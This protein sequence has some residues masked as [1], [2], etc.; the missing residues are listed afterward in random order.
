M[1]KTK[2]GLYMNEIYKSFIHVNARAKFKK[3]VSWT[4]AWR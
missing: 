1:N 2:H 4:V 3:R